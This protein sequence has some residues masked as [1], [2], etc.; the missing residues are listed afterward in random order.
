MKLLSKL[1][2]IL[3]VYL[4]L[5]CA[6]LTSN[7]LSEIPHLINY[8]GKLVDSTGTP[9]TGTKTITFK[10]YDVSSGGTPLWQETQ[11]V[12]VDKGVFNIL[13]GSS[14]DLGQLSFDVPYHLSIQVAGDAEMAPRQKISSAGYAFKAKKAENT[15]KIV[16][17]QASALPEINK[18]L[19]LDS[20]G[21]FPPS[22]L[23]ALSA[24]LKFSTRNIPNPGSGPPFQERISGLGFKPKC[25]MFIAT[26]NQ[27]RD[28]SI[29]I[30]DASLNSCIYTREEIFQGNKRENSET[31]NNSCIYLVSYTGYATSSANVTFTDSDGFILE[32]EPYR[33]NSNHNYRAGKYLWIAW[34]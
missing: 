3:I 15:E 12:I 4:T 34:E 17:I 14:S 16:G 33:R 30:S 9:I 7:C 27:S 10:I 26:A 25:I 6:L 24:K 13:L 19:A 1:F 23:P 29:G 2:L 18:L 32:W 5:S 20:E 11:S 21:K 31:R 22:V 8:Q 28:I